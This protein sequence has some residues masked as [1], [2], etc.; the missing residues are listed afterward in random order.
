MPHEQC[1]VAGMLLP[2]PQLHEVQCCVGSTRTHIRYVLRC[3]CTT[4]S[5]TTRAAPAARGAT[6][7]ELMHRRARITAG[8][9]T[10]IDPAT[11][12]RLALL[13]L[14]AA[15]AHTPE[16]CLPNSHISLT[17]LGLVCGAGSAPTHH[18]EQAV[19]EVKVIVGAEERRAVAVLHHGIEVN[20][21]RAPEPLSEPALAAR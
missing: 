18:I 2:R 17:Q 9:A 15:A 6:G 13:G 21:P 7:A 20:E 4:A 16:C 12:A 10:A 1:I 11:K 8:A 5:P 3:I 14:S 19:G